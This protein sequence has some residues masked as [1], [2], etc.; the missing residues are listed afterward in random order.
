MRVT[1]CLWVLAF[2]F[3]ALAAPPMEAAAKKSKRYGIEGFILGYD[4]EKQ[5]ARVKVIETKVLGRFA[6]GNPVG[7][8]APSDIKRGQEYDFAIEPEGSILRRTVIRAETGAGLD[9]SGTP[10]GF[11]EAY[12]KIPKDRLTLFSLENNSPDAIKN[13]APKYKIMLVQIQMTLEELIR[14]LEKIAVEE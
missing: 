6:T 4:D 11:R 8:K 5:T 10:E 13:G 2:V 3:V 12:A 14:R 9:L 1:T 7:G